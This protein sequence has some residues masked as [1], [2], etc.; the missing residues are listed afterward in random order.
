MVASSSW[1][2]ATSTSIL[3]IHCGPRIVLT[4]VA[5]TLA[6]LILL[7]CASFPL[8]FD[9]LLLEYRLAVLLIVLP[10][11]T[12]VSIPTCSS[13]FVHKHENRKALILKGIKARV[14]AISIVFPH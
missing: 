4:A 10:Y 7:C 14:G 9:C 6:A 1:V 8:F 5:T 2:F 11:L 3:S 13:T 12:S